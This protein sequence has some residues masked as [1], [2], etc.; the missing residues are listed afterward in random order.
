MGTRRDNGKD[1]DWEGA[2][3]YCQNLNLGGHSDWRLPTI[4][5]LEKLFDSNVRADFRIK[6]PFQLAGCCPWSSSMNG[7]GS[8]WFFNFYDGR[9]HDRP[10]V[11]FFY[12]RALCGRGSNK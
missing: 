2:K 11:A 5:E 9:R 4:Q 7:E 8:A 10:L 6:I 12:G 1:L 3:S